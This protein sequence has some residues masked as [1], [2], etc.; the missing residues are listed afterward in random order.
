V[1]V[2]PDRL[3]TQLE[4]A[5]ADAGLD[6][7]AWVVWIVDAVRPAGTTPIAYLQPAGEVRPNTVLVFRAV[8]SERVHPYRLTAHR[9]AIWR[10][11]PGLPE[12]ALGP[13]LRHELE[14]ARRWERSGTTFYEADERLRASVGRSGYA[15]LP[16]EREAN[17]AAAAYARQSLSSLQLA[18][19][20]ACS[21]FADLL[22]GEPAPADVVAATLALLGEQ[23]M[24]A[25]AMSRV[26]P[27]TWPS[28]PVGSGPMVEV[29]SSR[30]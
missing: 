18:E 22:A 25:G 15:K 21:E 24:P 20:R 9:L 6:P 8:G 5:C 16:T 19:L 2:D 23:A 27:Q 17:A 30:S 10:E 13:M 4:R 28:R 3:R 11:L 26:R 12:A 1:T 29:V 7:R 14:H